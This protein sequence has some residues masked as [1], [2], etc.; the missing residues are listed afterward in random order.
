MFKTTIDIL[1][2]LTI[3]LVF[4]AFGIM[5]VG[6]RIN[7][8]K[9]TVKERQMTKHGFDLY[10]DPVYQYATLKSKYES[11]RYAISQ[12]GGLDPDKLLECVTQEGPGDDNHIYK[13]AMIKSLK[14]VV[15]PEKRELTPAG[16]EE[17]KKWLGLQ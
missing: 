8:N 6:Q 3:V 12:I 13:L 11:L 9:D 14:V 4:F 17:G 7:S 2:L 5:V 15:D 10:N 1:E 16:I